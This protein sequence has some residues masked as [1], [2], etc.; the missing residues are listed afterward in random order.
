MILLFCTL[1]YVKSTFRT[2]CDQRVIIKFL[3]NERVD[4]RNIASGLQTQFG[5]HADALRT[6]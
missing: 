2:E 5:E 4:A 1:K 6:T 3:L